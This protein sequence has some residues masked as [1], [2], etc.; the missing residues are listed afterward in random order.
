LLLF[1][2]WI[3]SIWFCRFRVKDYMN[4]CRFHASD[5]IGR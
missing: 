1:T 2:R 3:N 4:I 5:Y